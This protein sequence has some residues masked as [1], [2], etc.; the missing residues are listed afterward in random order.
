MGKKG[1]FLPRGEMTKYLCCNADESEPGTFKDRELMF[2]NPHGL[3]EGIAITALAV[4]A[5]YAFI[6]VRGEYWE[7]A[8]VLDAAVR[9]AYDGGYLGEHP[10]LG[11]PRRAGGAPR[12]RRPTSAA[13][14]PRCST[15]S[16]AR[17][18]AA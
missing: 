5:T 6:F 3:I 13:R 9:E 16:K 1:T 17:R 18:A 11:P 14:R 15:R 10:R 2:K 4:D 8:D 12:R 7:V